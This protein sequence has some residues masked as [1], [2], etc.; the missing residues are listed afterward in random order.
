M[1]VAEGAYIP[2]YVIL[3]ESEEKTV[4]ADIVDPRTGEGVASEIS[5]AAVADRPGH[6]SNSDVIMPDRDNLLADVT[7]YELDG[8]TIYAKGMIII[9]LRSEVGGGGV[10]V[11]SSL[12]DVRLEDDSAL[13]VVLEDDHLHI[14]I[15]TEEV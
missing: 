4:R 5:L 13:E 2:L 14:I 12:V 10:A 11:D 15:D 9:N 7:V 3:E 6:Y 1:I 8:T